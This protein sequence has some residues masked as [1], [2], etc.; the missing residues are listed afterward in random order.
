M[1]G[2]NIIKLIKSIDWLKIWDW[3]KKL[4]I[5]LIIIVVLIIIVLFQQCGNYNKKNYDIIK[6]GSKKYELLSHKVDTVYIPKI[7]II[8]KPGEIIY[9]DT[10]IYVT[11]PI[12]IDTMAVIQA[13]YNKN[14]YKDTLKLDGKLGIINITDTITQNRI[15]TRR[16]EAQIN[17]AYINDITIVKELPKF[18]LYGGIYSQLNKADLFKSIGTGL[19]L[20][21]KQDRMYQLNIGVMNEAGSDLSPYFGVGMYWKIKFKKN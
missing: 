12:N 8:T 5:K 9:V 21:D 2:N 7:K 11:L 14:I 6:V 20:K 19:I 17:Q 18:Q 10:T 3:F 13:Y 4:D 16:W 1:T 15:L